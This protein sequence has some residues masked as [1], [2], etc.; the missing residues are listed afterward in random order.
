MTNDL[1]YD[2]TDWAAALTIHTSVVGID[3]EGLGTC[4]AELG[5][6]AQATFLIALRDAFDQLGLL[7][8][9]KQMLYISDAITSPSA[10]HD[11]VEFLRE[12]AD[13][14]DPEDTAVA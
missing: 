10:R 7:G 13:F 1:I 14:L 6:D 3:P 4:I 5:S 11:V 2:G 12:L 9:Q 8:R